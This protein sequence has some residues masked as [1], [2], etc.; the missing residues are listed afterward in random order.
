MIRDG[1]AVPLKQ[2]VHAAE[3][4]IIGQST[5]KLIGDSLIRFLTE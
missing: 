3:Y 5:G 2:V 1:L 4:E